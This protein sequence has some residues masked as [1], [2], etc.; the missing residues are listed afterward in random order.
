M[1]LKILLVVFVFILIGCSQVATPVTPSPVPT[2]TRELGSPGIKVTSVPD[3]Q[4]GVKAFLQAW[5]DEDY[6]KMYAMLTRLTQDAVTQADFEKRYRTTAISLTLKSIDYQV[7][8]TLVASPTNGQAAFRVTYNT[9]LL[10]QVTRDNMMNLSLENGAWKVQWEEGMVL[11][12]LRGGNYLQ[13]DYKIPARG[14]IYDRNGHAIVAQADAVA[15]GVVPG[16]INP[17]QEKTLLKVLSNLTGF[18][19]DYIYNLYKNAKPDWYIPVGE[20]SVEEA[21][22]QDS[23]LSNLSGLQS[24]P[25][26]SR[27]YYDSGV[28]A[29]AIGYV[30]SIS[31]E[32]LEQY[33]RMGYAG[34]EKIGADGL[35]AWGEEYLA[36]KHGADLYVKDSQG[37]IVTRIAQSDSAPA[38]SIYTTIDKDLQIK[39]QKSFGNLSG[40]AIVMERDTGRILAMVSSPNFDPNLFEPTNRNNQLLSQILNDPYQPLYNRAAQGV[41]PLGSV[42]KVITMSAALESGLYTKDTT[43]LCGYEFTEL[44]GSVLYDW[45]YTHDVPPSGLLTLPEGLMRSCNP[46]FWHIGLDLFQQGYG[47]DI[48][49]MARA[50]GLGSK[51]GMVENGEQ[52]GAIPDP[53][54]EGD[55]VQLA[56]GQ[57]AM[58]VTPLQVVDFIAAIG[59]GGILYRPQLVEKIVS[60]DGASIYTF[61]PVERGKLPLSQENLTLLQDAMRSVVANRRG[62]AF[63]VLANMTVP[64]A[65]KTGTAQNPNGAAHAWFTGYSL[66]NRKDKPDIAVVVLIENGGEGSEMAAPIFRR[67]VSLYFSDNTNSGGVMP[68]EAS[69]YVVRSPTPSETD[70]PTP[71]P[72]PVLTE[73]PA[74]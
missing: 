3:I 57:G 48:P 67:A 11:P 8:S 23:I 60:V 10:N 40:A 47:M 54:S 28:A 15:L 29:Q 62:T 58:L 30:L 72:E 42:F 64:V 66:A 56:I 4:P 24:W 14:N 12:E 51:T 2:A 46:F 36:G 41:F 74:P 25:F 22:A 33:Q 53:T 45:T 43:Y 69:P 32:Q 71:T 19:T 1:K 63:Y 70:T 39:L 17:D 27:Y 20:T 35:E 68:W 26:R 31:P 61:K 65:G 49:T 21:Q 13:I 5:K 59:N 73:T 37:Q 7:L 9:T 44:P 52:A 18:Q 16:E 38:Q 55:A 6:P 34:D 50:F